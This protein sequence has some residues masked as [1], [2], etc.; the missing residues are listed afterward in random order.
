MTDSPVALDAVV[1]LGGWL[2]LPGPETIHPPHSTEELLPGPGPSTRE[3]ARWILAIPEF[4]LLDGSDADWTS[5]RARWRSSSSYID[6]GFD[7]SYDESGR[8]PGSPILFARCTRRE[9]LSVWEE[10]RGNDPRIWLSD[11]SASLHTPES[12]ASA[13]AALFE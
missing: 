7:V 3:V 5:W 11:P 4:L 1:D 9:F 13:P 8:W 2:L 10:L 6:L 12:F